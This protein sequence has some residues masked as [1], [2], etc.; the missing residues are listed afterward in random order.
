MIGF[1]KRYASI[2]I[3]M[4]KQ[5]YTLNSKT[6]TSCYYLHTNVC[7]LSVAFQEVCYV[8]KET[9]D[10]AMN[11]TDKVLSLAEFTF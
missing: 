5:L 2:S 7:L 10:L 1:E 3:I 9:Q 8:L 6:T 4:P 11:K